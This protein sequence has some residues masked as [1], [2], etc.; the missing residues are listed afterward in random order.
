MNVRE[1]FLSVMSFEPTDRT[2]LWELGYWASTVRRWYA[3]GLPCRVGVPDTL[4]DG[5]NVRGGIAPWD[6]VGRPREDDLREF[7]GM[8]AGIRRIPVNLFLSP[9]YE[10]KV[11][12]DH[13]E[14]VLTVDA[15]GA[16]IKERKDHATLPHYV[17]W[18][19]N[20]REDWEAL[21][22][23]RLRPTLEGRLPTNWPQIREELGRRDYPVTALGGGVGFFGTPRYLMGPENLL[24]AFIDQPALVH[25]MIDYLADLWIEITD[26]VLDQVD[27]DM[28]LIWEDMC[29]KAGPLISPAMFREFMLPAYQKVTSF[30]RDRG[31][32]IVHVDTDGNCWSLLPLFV[33]G[34]VT[35]LWPF[36]VNAGMNVV[37]VRKAFPRLQILGGLDKLQMAADLAAIDDELQR[38]VL[39]LLGVG[40]YVPAMDHVVPPYVSWSNF[41]YY[42]NR[43]NEIIHEAGATSDAK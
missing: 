15:H 4:A 41:H 1:R 20:D 30:L 9:P 40:G 43:L 13:G 37:E 25:D 34:G 6:E 3:E 12:E 24:M 7:F 33:E 21:K 32:R 19:V 8:D 18:A 31:I 10:E 27:A 23:E 42:R 2:L 16:T 14:W 11:L 5:D 22:A 29:Y 38:K 28:A 39:P 35:G 26:K 36:E 17:G